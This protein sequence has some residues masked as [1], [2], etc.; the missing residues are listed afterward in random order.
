MD[1]KQGGQ[2]SQTE[3]GLDKSVGLECFYLR[4]SPWSF[5]LWGSQGPRLKNWTSLWWE[6]MVVMQL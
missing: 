1:R 3:S 5:E 6:K 2:F 4:K